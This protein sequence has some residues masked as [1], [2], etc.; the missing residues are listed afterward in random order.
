MKSKSNDLVVGLVILLG[1]GLLI[2]ATLWLQR[3]DLGGRKREVT[4]RFRDAGNIR[5]GGT[6]NIRGVT[7]GRVDRLELADS[8]WVHVRVRLQPE[9]EL[10]PEPVMVLYQ[11]SLF[12]EWA[13]TFVQRNVAEAVGDDAKRDLAE[14][15]TGA[16]TLLPG[17]VLPD[18]AQLTA[19]A[20]QIAGSFSKIADRFG[21]AF[22][23][24]AAL[25]LRGT[26]RSTASLARQL[27]RSV[28]KQSGNLDT[29]ALGLID[30][31]LALDSAAQAFRRTAARADAA[32][33]SD[34]LRRLVVDAG[35]S[36]AALRD[37]AKTLRD[38]SQALAADQGSLKSVAAR[39][40]TVMRR[41]SSGDGTMGLL[42]RDPALYRNTDSL[43]IELRG[44]VADVKA[45]PRK[46]VNVRVF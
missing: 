22:N 39:A 35:E 6:V 10:P 5:V 37:A 45:N 36:A 9:I 24:T 12:G 13:A 2:G 38:L 19:V 26:F 16:G 29:L 23:D 1:L 43:L 46:Y 20:G 17:I 21:R 8:G 27:E 14:A 33:Q 41:L 34:E 15:S 4:A 30:A 42:L 3:A 28:K 7:A 11:Q 31:T 25:E 32:T 44:L 18:I 40:D